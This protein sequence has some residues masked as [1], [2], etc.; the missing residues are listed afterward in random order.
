MRK[1]AL[2]ILIAILLS[3]SRAAPSIISAQGGGSRRVNAPYFDGEVSFPET[4]I[5]WFDQV[6]GTSNYADVRVGYNDSHLYLRLAAFDRWLWYDTTP[7]ADDLTAWDAVSLYLNLD[8]NEG[9]APDANAYRFVGQLNWW[10]E[11][12]PFQTAYRGDGSGWLSAA[13]P[14]TTTSGWRGNAPNH[15]ERDDR[16]W[17]LAFRIPFAGLGLSGPPPEGTVWGMAITLHDRDD[18]VGTAIADQVWP[19]T[20]DADRP[21]TWGQMAF[22][23]PTYA[24]PLATARGAITIR[25]KLNGA[26]VPD[27]AVGGTTGAVGGT[28]GNLCPGDAN[29]IWN[30]WGNDNFAGAPDFNIQN[31]ADVADWPC[32]AKYYVT[33][34]LSAVPSGKVIVSATLTLHHWGGSDP[35]QAEPSLI[36][37]LTVA[38]DW[39]EST[40]TWNNAPLA[41]ENVAATWVDV[42]TS[43]SWPGTPCTW[44][45]SGA[46]AE[47]YASGAPLRLALYEAD[48]AYH[49]GKYFVSSDTGDWNAE[50]RP[51]LTVRVQPIAPLRGQVVTYT[52]S[53]LGNGQA[54]TLTDDL[55]VEVSAPGL[56][57][58]SDGTMASYEPGAHR[59]VWSGSPGVGQSVSITFPV[60]VQAA[61][62]LAVLNTAVLT[63]AEGLVSSDTAVFI[64]DARQVWLPSIFQTR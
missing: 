43:S 39:D 25:H 11:R 3:A 33:F 19:E 2:V 7:S 47:A 61:G 41:A 27:V 10:E 15:N 59:I 12:G 42:D 1:S 6:D 13:V 16:G 4:A 32:F 36:Q 48:S 18:E 20:A 24:L 26:V 22:G 28:T 21:S 52:L 37:V 63:D 50:G 51:T 62:P 55:P 45:V 5:F 31:Q 46:V 23:L 38:E 17:A 8:G 58:V 35:S 56:I 29:Y 54:I 64:V 53:L 49:S 9:E 60:T 34:P 14:F 40:L 44:D 57:Q 30:E